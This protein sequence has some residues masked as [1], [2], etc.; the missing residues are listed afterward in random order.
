MFMLSRFAVVQFWFCT[1]KNSFW[2]K[3][4]LCPFKIKAD[5][6]L[7]HKAYPPPPPKPPPPSFPWPRPPPPPAPSLEDTTETF[8]SPGNENKIKNKMSWIKYMFTFNRSRRNC[9][10][11][12]DDDWNYEKISVLWKIH[13]YLL[14]L[15]HDIN[16][17]L[18]IIANKKW[19]SKLFMCFTSV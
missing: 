16:F 10:Y 18:L 13:N 8:M 17:F 15:S 4:R 1:G 5:F 19:K 3:K 7:A 2:H 6:S 14:M 12:K 9:R 11:K